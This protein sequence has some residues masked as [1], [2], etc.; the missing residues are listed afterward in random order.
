VLADV[1]GGVTVVV[2]V[3][4]RAR[5]TAAVGYHGDA[6]KLAVAAAP[7]EGAANE[8]VLQLVAK[9][10]GVPP[11]SV[12]IVSGS[13]SRRKRVQICGISAREATTILE[14]IFPAK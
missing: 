9:V 1:D 12:Q 4:P 6:L 5:R 2:H 8:A 11:R 10:F 3:Q 14:A 13:S 7:H